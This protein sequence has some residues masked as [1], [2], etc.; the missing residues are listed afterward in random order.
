MSMSKLARVA[1]AA[2]SIGGVALAAATP[3]LAATPVPGPLLGAGA[4]VVAVGALGYWLI[5]RYRRRGE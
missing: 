3:A 1:A 5:R 4:P 2:V